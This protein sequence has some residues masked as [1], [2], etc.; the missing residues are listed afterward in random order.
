MLFVLLISWIYSSWPI[1]AVDNVWIGI[2][3][4]IIPLILLFCLQENQ[5]ASLAVSTRWMWELT[6][7]HILS[8]LTTKTQLFIHGN[9]II[10][11]VSRSLL[12]C[13]SGCNSAVWCKETSGRVKLHLFNSQK[14]FHY[15]RSDTLSFQKLTEMKSKTMKHYV[16]TETCANPW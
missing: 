16:I 1:K 4:W 6:S 7:K 5:K 10:F 11:H 9:G 14:M 2:V 3:V 13:S 12:S 15:Q 8:F